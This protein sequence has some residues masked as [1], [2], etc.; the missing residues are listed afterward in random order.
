[1][2]YLLPLFLSAAMV[3]SADDNERDVAK[4]SEAMGHLIG[5]NLQAL[6]LDLDIQAIVK[7]LKDASEGKRPPMNED[8]CVQ[9]IA[10]L[11]EESFSAAA[12]KNRQEADEFLSKNAQEENVVSLENGKL[13]YK[14]LKRGDGQSVQSYNS[15]II[16]YTARYLDGQ[17]FG[18]VTDE[19]L[20][21]LDEAIPGLSKGLVGMKEGEI[22]TLFL[23]P[24][25]GYGKQGH[26]LPNA[27]LIFDIEV[28]KA[29]A[30][31]D[32]QAA[33]NVEDSLPKVLEEAP[34][35]SALAR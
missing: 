8:E 21:S 12:E 6:G 1:M 4:I 14:I 32:A 2:K 17:I 3:C 34:E 15:P 33:S 28:I 20:I 5:K 23:H 19:E 31:A 9:A 26:L 29:D 16:R 13:Q 11:Q 10:A 22:R 7:G 30:S 25:L 24:D 35:E 27:L 18:A